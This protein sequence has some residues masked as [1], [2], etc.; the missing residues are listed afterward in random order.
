MAALAVLELP[1]LLGWKEVPFFKNCSIL[2]I[3]DFNQV[4]VKNSSNNWLALLLL[5]F[6]LG[7]G[8]AAHLFAE[9]HWENAL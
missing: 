8:A 1:A 5:V 7:V 6:I 4:L 9:E 2:R 3:A